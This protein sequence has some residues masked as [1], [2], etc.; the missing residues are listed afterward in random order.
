MVGTWPAFSWASRAALSPAS[1][2]ASSL[3]LKVP[4]AG[5]A[6]VLGLAVRGGRGGGARRHGAGAPQRG[7]D[8]ASGDHRCGHRTGGD[9]H[10]DSVHGLELL[11][12]FLN[13]WWTGISEIG[14][15]KDQVG[16]NDSRGPVR[17]LRTC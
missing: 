11:L 16:G 4:A 5:A 1:W 6:P 14:A 12:A 15:R 7:A 10:P 13:L 8:D 2:V 17:T 3:G 9:G